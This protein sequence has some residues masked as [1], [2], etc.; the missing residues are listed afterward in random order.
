MIERDY[1]MRMISQLT[2][3]LARVLLHKHAHEFPLVRKELQSAYKSLLGL[4]PA[5]LHQFSDAQLI[6]MFGS[7]EDIKATKSYVLG[8]LMK[9]EA[10]ILLLEGN[11][12]ESDRMF[13]RA[14]NMLLFSFNWAGNEA[15]AGHLDKID[16]VLL[17]LYGAE[18]PVYTDEQLLMCYEA[19]GRY[20]KAENVLFELCET[21]PSWIDKGLAFYQRLLQLSDEQLAAGGFSR[22]EIHAGIS[23]LKLGG[24][25]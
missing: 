12:D 8:S 11:A 16:S 5:L 21:D 15:E 23:D 18:F 14:L 3:S 20:D 19:T 17:N 1:I 2:Q 6:E 13:L 7:D 10:E 9:E 25:S 24:H 4:T 22:D